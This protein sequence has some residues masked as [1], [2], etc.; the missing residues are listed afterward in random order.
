MYKELNET[1]IK[2]LEDRIK[3]IEKSIEDK[4]KVLSPDT[5]KDNK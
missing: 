2:S 1:L 4:I 5:K 3:K